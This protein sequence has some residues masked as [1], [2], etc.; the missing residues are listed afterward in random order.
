MNMFYTILCIAT[1]QSLVG[2]V[3]IQRAI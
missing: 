2:L 1:A 3:V